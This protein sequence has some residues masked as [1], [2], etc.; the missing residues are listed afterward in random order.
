VPG[1]LL[2]LGTPQLA[3]LCATGTMQT[4]HFRAAVLGATCHLDSILKSSFQ[5]CF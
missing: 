4:Q 1:S 3:A 2:G 5:P